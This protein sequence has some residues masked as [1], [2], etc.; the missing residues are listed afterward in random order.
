MIFS[1]ASSQALCYILEYKGGKDQQSPYFKAA[2]RDS[3][4]VLIF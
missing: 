2:Y 1:P 4:L 3:S